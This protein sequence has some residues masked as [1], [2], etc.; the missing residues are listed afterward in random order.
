MKKKK[1]KPGYLVFR[2]NI[3]SPGA[4][5]VGDVFPEEELKKSYKTFIGK[6]VQLGQCGNF[7]IDKANTI[8]YVMDAC[9]DPNYNHIECVLAVDQGHPAIKT[10]SLI[11][12]NESKR[13]KETWEEVVMRHNQKWRMEKKRKGKK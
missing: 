12:E 2:V 10:L 1:V 4:I 9:W 7:E 3:L 5:G 13:F 6:R 8:G 11:K